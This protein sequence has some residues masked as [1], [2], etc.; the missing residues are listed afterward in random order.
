[1]TPTPDADVLIARITISG[2]PLHL[3]DAHRMPA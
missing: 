3:A 2:A 1:M